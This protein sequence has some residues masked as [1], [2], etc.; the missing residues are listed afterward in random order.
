M[1]DPRIEAAARALCI[2]NGH[3]PDGQ[4]SY[5]QSGMDANW[6]AF[7]D[8]AKAA[9]AAA[10]AAAWRPIE[11]APKDGSLIL[12]TV[13]H[14]GC[15]VVSFWGTGWRETTNG[16]MLRDEP[17]H[18]Q[19]LPTPPNATPQAAPGA[20]TIPEVRNDRPIPGKGG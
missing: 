8:D 5:V 15:D 10:G 3:D 2:Q 11:T 7:V 4:D 13:K 19:P 9:L 16:L 20:I 17:T 6:C 18:W 1:T 12:V 14:I